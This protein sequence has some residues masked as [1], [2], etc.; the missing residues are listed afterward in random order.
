MLTTENA[1]ALAAGAVPS[2]LVIP[3]NEHHETVVSILIYAGTVADQ[4]QAG[5]V[6]LFADLLAMA[7]AKGFGDADLMHAMIRR[8]TTG[9]LMRELVL[10]VIDVMGGA[11]SCLDAV[12]L[13]TW[14]HE[15]VAQ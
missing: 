2:R 7:T 3:A 4:V 15:G 9:P 6:S 10:E 5:Q 11:S 1:A 13:I 12:D 8:R 14:P